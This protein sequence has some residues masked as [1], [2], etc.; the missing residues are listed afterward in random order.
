M[1]LSEIVE[2][3]EKDND[4]R[5]S[6]PHRSTLQSKW[7]ENFELLGKNKTSQRLMMVAFKRA[8]FL[9]RETKVVSSVGE[10]KN[11]S[12]QGN[13]VKFWGQPERTDY[14]DYLGFNSAKNIMVIPR[15]F[16]TLTSRITAPSK[17]TERKR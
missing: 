2:G 7:H 6:D 5:E 10:K 14:L 1:W 15:M 4:S 3:H 12:A 8:V 13:R 16:I 9:R 11:I 17:E